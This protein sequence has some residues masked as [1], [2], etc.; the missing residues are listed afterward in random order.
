MEKRSLEMP[1][2]YFVFVFKAELM[3]YWVTQTNNLLSARLHLPSGRII[4][5]CYHSG[6][7]FYR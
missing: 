1:C 3:G 7:T 5:M 2:F 6:Q 4:S